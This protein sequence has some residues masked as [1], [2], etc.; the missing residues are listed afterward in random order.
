ML[1]YNGKQHYEYTPYFHENYQVFMN[2]VNRDTILKTYCNKNK[3]KLLQIPYLDNDRLEE[4]I[5]AF[6]IE[7]KDITTHIQ[8][9]LLPALIYD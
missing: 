6:V 4:V 5:R 3:I 9:K 2:Q 7:G 1:E 8:P